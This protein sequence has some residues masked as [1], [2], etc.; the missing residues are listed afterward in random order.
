M[1][2]AHVGHAVHRIVAGHQREICAVVQRHAYLRTGVQVRIVRADQ[3][4]YVGHLTGRTRLVAAETQI[5]APSVRG[6]R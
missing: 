5:A 2:H 4:R 3:V 1:I 6:L